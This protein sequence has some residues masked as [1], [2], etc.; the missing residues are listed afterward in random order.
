MNP[1]Y[2]KWI[3]EDNVG[4]NEDIFSGNKLKIS[5]TSNEITTVLDVITDGYDLEVG[6]SNFGAGAA[7]YGSNATVPTS[8]VSSLSIDDKGRA[9]V[10]TSTATSSFVRNTSDNFGSVN[11]VQQ[12]ITLTDAEYLAITPDNSTLYIIVG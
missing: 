8:I 6:L 7:D 3:I 12:I 4:T 5:G 9:S 2:T 11:A 10:A 1:Q